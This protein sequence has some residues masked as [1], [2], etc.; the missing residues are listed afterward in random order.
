MIGPILFAL[1]LAALTVAAV[2][3]IGRWVY[4]RFLFYSDG[5]KTLLDSNLFR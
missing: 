1:W 5:L 4:V 2:P 3:P